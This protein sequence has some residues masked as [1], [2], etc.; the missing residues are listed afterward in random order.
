M[1]DLYTYATDRHLLRTIVQRDYQLPEE[2]DPY[3]F[4][5]A[6]L[7]NLGS[8][9]SE[10]RDEL[11]ALIFANGIVARQLLTPVQQVD[12]LR[13]LLGNEHLFYRIGEIDTDTV[14][15]R[16]FSN[17][18]IAAILYSDAQRQTLSNEL[19]KQTLSELL[20]YAREERDW[21]GYVKGKGWAHTMAHLAG[22]LDECAQNRFMGVKERT[23][24]LDTVGRLA[25]LAVPLYHEEDVRLAMVV[26][27]IILGKQV[28][29]ATLDKWID[30]CFVS[31]ESDVESWTRGTNAKNFLRSLYFLLHWEGV[32]APLAEHISVILKQQD[33]IFMDDHH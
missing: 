20:R 12:L 3:E 6:L 14:F 7:P 27:H 21:R 15:M 9:D 33:A 10:L 28:D 16:S 4:A 31:R 26:Y 29:E 17:L 18:A 13:T 1:P 22:T 24:I 23:E 8:P 2:L 30:R 5:R 25:R 11:S 32:A 19:V